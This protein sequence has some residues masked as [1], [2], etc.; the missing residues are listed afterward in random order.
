MRAGLTG[1]AQVNGLNGDT[2]ITER[3]RFDNFYIDNWSFWFDVVILARTLGLVARAVRGTEPRYRSSGATPPP[4]CGLIIHARSEK[5]SRVK[6]LHII[7]GLGVGGAELQLRSVIQHSRH[8][9]DVVTLYNPGPVADMFART[10]SGSGIW[11][12]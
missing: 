3:V 10:A 12:W 11:E 9:C 5:G 2:S 6:V 7:T 4:P 1:W 8:D